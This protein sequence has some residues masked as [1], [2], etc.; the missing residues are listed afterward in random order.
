MD[1]SG[2]HA[3]P[4]QR[5]CTRGKSGLMRAPVHCARSAQL[6]RLK[7]QPSDRAHGDRARRTYPASLAAGEVAV[8]LDAIGGSTRRLARRPSV[9]ILELERRSSRAA[10][11]QVARAARAAPHPPIGGA[12][13]HEGRVH[14]DVPTRSRRPLRPL[15]FGP[16][17][18]IACSFCACRHFRR[19]GMLRTDVLSALGAS[20]AS[21]PARP[22]AGATPSRKVE[23][24]R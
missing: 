22:N 1:S 24:T 13:P 12:H 16:F 2:S 20:N 15:R 14:T 19:N 4:R 3:V 21:P 23:G 7:S 6:D 11:L 8:L 17:H 5:A 10:L 9:R 18:L